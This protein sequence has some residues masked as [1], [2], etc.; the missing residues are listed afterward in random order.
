[1]DAVL[2]EQEDVTRHRQRG[3]R[4][5]QPDTQSRQQQWESGSAEWL[6]SYG[7][8]VYFMLL[9]HQTWYVLAAVITQGPSYYGKLLY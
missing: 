6:G 4:C 5:I 1:M 3:I 7:L 2:K 8:K 9:Y